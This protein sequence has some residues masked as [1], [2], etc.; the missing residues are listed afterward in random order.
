VLETGVPITSVRF[1][2]DFPPYSSSSDAF[3]TSEAGEI[4]HVHLS[5]LKPPGTTPPPP[6]AAVPAMRLTLDPGHVR[7]G[8]ATSVRAS[9]SSVSSSCRA[10]VSVS[11][12]PVTEMTGTGGR[13]RF[14]LRETHTGPI[15]ATA[16]KAGCQSTSVQLRVVAGGVPG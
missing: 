7:A 4:I 3:L 1:A 11:L 6:S 12:G 2:V 14:R 9:V 13:A 16:R 5:G 15:T 10:G 8:H